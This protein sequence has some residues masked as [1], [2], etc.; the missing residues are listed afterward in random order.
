MNDT[1]YVFFIFFLCDRNSISIVALEKRKTEHLIGKNV[2]W[3]KDGET[4]KV[5]EYV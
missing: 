2:Q 4:T 3:Q 1:L 5:Y